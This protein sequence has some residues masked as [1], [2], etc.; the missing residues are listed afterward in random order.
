MFKVPE[1]HAVTTNVLKKI[2][3]NIWQ[4]CTEEF[5]KNSKGKSGKHYFF[6]CE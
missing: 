1:M 3:M 5:N 6:T 4:A 2:Y